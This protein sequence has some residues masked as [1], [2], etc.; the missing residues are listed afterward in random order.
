MTRKRITASLLAV[1]VFC[2]ISFSNASSSSK[3]CNEKCLQR[4]Q[5]MSTLREASPTGVISM[6]PG[7]FKDLL[8][9]RPRQYDVI[10]LLN[11]LHPNRRC[12]HC[13]A[14]QSE[15][16]IVASSFYKA[17]PDNDE[18][19]FASVDFDGNEDIFRKLQCQSAPVFFHVPKAGKPI[20]HN[21][22]LLAA[23]DISN[24]VAGISKKKIIIE[25][26]PNYMGMMITVLVAI[27]VGGVIYVLRD[28]VRVVI[29]NPRVWGWFSVVFVL[30]MMSGHMWLQ[31][32][33]APYTMQ[34]QDGTVSVFSGSS[35]FQLGAESHAVILLYG[36]TAAGIVLINEKAIPAKDG[37]PTQFCVT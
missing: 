27:V 24:F 15:F 18:V 1:L 23:E 22:Q 4:T 31:I 3:S 37:T 2:A 20:R 7:Y 34:N 14:T 16:G 17:F 28:F 19:F 35:Q 6:N 12:T 36:L 21:Q 8:Q 25:R 26:P 13:Q 32:R 33:G 5:Q 29:S 10:L 11:A 30:M 9:T